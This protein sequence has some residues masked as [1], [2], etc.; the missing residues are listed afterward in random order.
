MRELVLEQRAQDDKTQIAIPAPGGPRIMM[1][2][3]P[4][5]D[6]WLFRVRVSDKQAI[7]GFPKF[8]QIGIGFAVE[9]ADWNTNLP[10]T[11]DAEEIYEH[12]KENKGDDAISRETCLEAIQMIQAAVLEMDQDG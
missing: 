1:S 10:A 6:Y 4:G 9:D 8:F 12:I 11:C 7:L 2:P 5:P 3:A